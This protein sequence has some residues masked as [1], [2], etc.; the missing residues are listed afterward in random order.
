[1]LLVGANQ[2]FNHDAMLLALQDGYARLPDVAIT[3]KNDTFHLRGESYGT[4]RLMA[5][6]VKRDMYGNLVP[7]EGVPP[8]ISKKFIVGGLACFARMQCL[9]H[10]TDEHTRIHSVQVVTLPCTCCMPHR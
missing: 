3:D 5:R 7:V 4:F 2:C 9:L 6:V 10:S 8:A 1:M